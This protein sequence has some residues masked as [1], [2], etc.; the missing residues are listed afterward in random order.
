MGTLLSAVLVSPALATDTATSTGTAVSV[1][2]G[3]AP[4]AV[5]SASSAVALSTY[6]VSISTPLPA[7]AEVP[8]PARPWVL[9]D[10]VVVGNKN[11]KFN[12]VRSEI[13]AKKG[14]IYDR[15]DLDRDIQSV[16]GLG[17]FERVSADVTS[18][19]KPVPEQYRK[20]AGSST[21][22]RLTLAVVE[23]PVIKKIAFEGN[24]KLSKGQLSDAISL[25]TK[26][27]L[28]N[29]KL[30]EDEDKIVKKYNEKG[31][32]DAT[33]TGSVEV[34]TATLQATVTFH[35]VEGAKSKIFW[36]WVRGVKAFKQ[37]K[38]EKQMTNRRKKV[39]SDKDLPE[40]V[41]KLEA[42]YKNRGFLDVKVSSPTV[43][44]SEDKERIY[45]D[46]TIDEGRPY[47]F[48]QTTFSG[49][50]V[51]VS[52]TLA[53]TLEYHRGKIFN[54]EKFDESI[55]AV[56]ELYAD[57]G[58]L[59][60]RVTPTKTYNPKTD[61]MDVNFEISEGDIVYIDHVDVEG[62]KSTKT[63]ILKREVT[64]KPGDM[65]KAS[66]VRKSREKIMNLGFIDD[67]DI[68]IQSPTD[69]DKVDLTYDVTEGKP[70][71]LT[72]GAAY[73][74]IDGLIGTLSL[75]HMN[76]FGRAQR[77]SVQWSF[78]K[79]VLDY[80]VS[81]TTPW[82]GNHPTSLGID[83]FNTR[84][85]NPFQNSISA[86]TEK[87]TGATLRLGPRFNDDMYH[88]N[89][90]YTIS[91]IQVSDVQD[92]FNTTLAPSTSLYSSVSGEFARD[93]RDNIWDPT[94]G[95]RHSIGAQLA[96]GPLGG[97]IDFFK[98]SLN[99]SVHFKLFS[100]EDY[101]L[102]LTFANRAAY[103]TPFG[104][105]KEVPVF[106]RFYLGGQDT[107][108]GYAPTGQVGFPSGGKMFDVFNVELGFPLARE[109]R[110][111][112]VKVVTFFDAGSA[113]DR[114]KDVSGRVGSGDRDI[115]TDVG[116]GIRFTT[117]AFP[118]RLDWGWGFNHIPGEKR[119]EIN[120]GLGNLF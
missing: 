103:I 67:V 66:K 59:R 85:I 89:M 21:T 114:M 120:F 45:I 70:G 93:T 57:V 53:K 40:D 48:G 52:S 91:R 43:W 96:G 37:S 76:L 113:W 60:A 17:D 7:P 50:E 30:H 62:N 99:D 39:F 64:T 117:P 6:T 5:S 31:F 23:K 106:N 12:V 18:T 41:K 4:V 1:T 110:K 65:F 2:T 54:Q 87:N 24:D 56:Q 27:P 74:S 95:S 10:I 29:V 33:A 80:S 72:A 98:P 79:R 108:R 34:D 101:P 75:Q 68:D 112:I 61:Q 118:I 35:V 81:W 15:P 16:L 36:V 73:S 83:L 69:P 46:L 71:V 47:K 115:K 107:L 94:S 14:D 58:R 82:V 25:K 49:N 22:I 119:Y 26:D 19:G 32:L 44:T 3:A 116:L 8:T 20:V 13:K 105:T 111:T 38:I 88:L 102:V 97:S 9:G 100:V 109:R 28:D 11:V 51:Y 77:A 86:Y 78:G 84:R 90:S 42:Y 92:Q 55:R 104:D 63:Y